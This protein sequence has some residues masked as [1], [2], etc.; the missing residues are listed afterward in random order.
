MDTC[1]TSHQFKLGV[2]IGH[3]VVN[4]MQDGATY[5]EVIAT[6]DHTVNLARLNQAMQVDFASL[7]RRVPQGTFSRHPATNI[8]E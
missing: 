3:L 2:A 5:D 8:G 1:P 4:A 7:S 6:L